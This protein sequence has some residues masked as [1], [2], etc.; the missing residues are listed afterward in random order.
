MASAG[1]HL[2]QGKGLFTGDRGERNV[3]LHQKQ[4]Q[5]IFRMARPTNEVTLVYLEETV[6]PAT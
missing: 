6:T 4:G 1:G 3:H 2:T 5:R